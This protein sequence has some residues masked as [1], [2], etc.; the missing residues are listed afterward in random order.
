MSFGHENV[1]TVAVQVGSL[2]TNNAERCVFYAS[3]PCT[4]TKAVL[5]NDVAVA[6]DASNY[7]TETLTN[8]GINGSG[9][10][11]VASNNTSNASG[12]A[13]VA[14]APWELALSSTLANRVV[15]TGEV[16]S[17]VHTEA[18]TG[19]DLASATLV[20]EYVRGTGPAQ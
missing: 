19:A 14:E 13:I 11:A 8:K 9:S 7:L 20:I 2:T 10:T 6:K 18:G 4:I 1:H 5:L 15:D 17:L 12:Q 16:L 3:A